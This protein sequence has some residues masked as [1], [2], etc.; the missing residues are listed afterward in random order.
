M[1]L[2]V[3]KLSHTQ[4]GCMR[5]VVSVS[6]TQR[7]STRLVVSVP[8]TRVYTLVYMYVFHT[9][10]VYP[11]VYNPLLRYPGGITWCITLS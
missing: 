1:R 9:R 8:H 4:G 6:H 10:E 2:M 11:G 7:G 5:L 3:Y